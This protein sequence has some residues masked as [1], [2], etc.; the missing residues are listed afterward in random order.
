[1]IEVW[2]LLARNIEHAPQT[3]KDLEAQLTQQGLHSLALI[4]H[5]IKT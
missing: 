2:H 5:L 4:V 1:M 3:V